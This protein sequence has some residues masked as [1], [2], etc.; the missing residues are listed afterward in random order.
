MANDIPVSNTW[1]TAPMLEWLKE[2]RWE[3]DWEAVAKLFN[4]KFKESRSVDAIRLAFGRNVD[5][6]LTGSGFKYWQ[7][8]SF[9]SNTTFTKTKQTY[10][11]SAIMP[12]HTII[13]DNFS[14]TY[15]HVN[16]DAFRTVVNNESK[17]GILPVILPMRAHTRPLETA[18]SIYDP[19]LTPWASW[20]T[21]EATFNKNLR[22]IDMRINP[23]QL[24][25]LTSMDRADLNSSVIVASPRQ[26]LEVVATGNTT[27]A[28]LLMSTGVLSYAGYQPNRIGKLAERAHKIGGIIVEVDGPTFFARR[29]QFDDK[30]GYHDLDTYHH[31]NETHQTRV[32]ALIFGDIHFGQGDDDLQRVA[33]ELI[34]LLKPRRLLFHDAF[35][36]LSINHHLN[37]VDKIMR[38]DW[39][40][41]LESEAALVRK[42]MNEL[43]ESAPKDCQIYWV[44]SNHNDFLSRYLKDR[45]YFNDEVN[46][47]VAHELQLCLLNG[48]NPI[49]KLLNL[50]YIQHLGMNEDL[51]IKGIQT[52]NH[53]HSGLNGARGTRSTLG[54]T[55][56]KL[57]TGHTHTPF[58]KDNHTGLG[59]WTRP[60]HGYN[61]GASTWLP[62]CGIIHE[63]GSTQQVIPILVGSKYQYRRKD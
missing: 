53:G 38:P 8:K 29:V 3:G 15:N 63:D 46:F 52:A 24:Q 60:R 43:K 58:E 49:A 48:G 54:K 31:F 27:Q 5:N 57:I 34:I 11:I 17:H 33:K 62:S 30:G 13:K 47:K 41:S 32:E 28:R 39:A 14:Y 40:H 6:D 26:N 23:Q 16:M 4:K 1:I 45:R 7:R 59:M 22:A 61:N 35:D 44:A 25:P 37:V 56:S 36:G 18:P 42:M 55:A 10:F 20:F 12:L 9:D 51:F 50:D 19:A 2:N 21:E